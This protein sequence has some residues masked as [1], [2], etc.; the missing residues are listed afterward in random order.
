MGWFNYF[1]QLCIREYRQKRIGYNR[2]TGYNIIYLYREHWRHGDS[3]GKS[4]AWRCVRDEF[5]LPSVSSRY[6]VHSFEHYIE[7]CI[8]T[9]TRTSGGYT[10]TRL[11]WGFNIH[12]KP[13]KRWINSIYKYMY[14]LYIYYWAYGVLWW[15]R[16][17]LRFD[18]NNRVT[19]H[20]FRLGNEL[21]NEC[22]GSFDRREK[23]HEAFFLRVKVKAKLK[24]TL[25]E[26]RKR[27]ENSWRYNLRL[28][29]RAA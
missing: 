23:G 18:Y 4:I 27:K 25:L 9:G 3:G 28:R 22:E 11:E 14:I 20:P 24:R 13:I 1:C 2:N 15:I 12:G 19:N 26:E 29:E 6:I 5:I 21:T 17:F 16:S 7:W 10:I 8:R